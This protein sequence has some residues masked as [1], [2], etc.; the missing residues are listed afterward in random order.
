MGVWNVWRVETARQAVIALLRRDPD[1]Y[2]IEVGQY[3][4]VALDQ[5]NNHS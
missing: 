1:S 2:L 5:L 4:Q 3:P